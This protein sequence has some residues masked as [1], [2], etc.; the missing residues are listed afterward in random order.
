MSK[1]GQIVVGLPEGGEDGFVLVTSLVILVVLTIIGMA[2][3]TTTQIE[4]QISGNDRVIRRQFYKADG[5]IN[6]IIAKNHAP[7]PGT[8]VYAGL[9][10][11]NPPVIPGVGDVLEVDGL[12]Q[13][14]VDGDGLPDANIYLVVGN[15]N[16]VPPEIEVVSCATLNSATAQ[17]TAG[18]RFSNGGPLQDP[19]DE[20]TYNIQ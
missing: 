7:P 20:N 14:D 19:G 5:A 10:C 11:N 4:I 15:N 12:E 2:A 13:V 6:Y 17:I 3:L 1:R 8:P 9:D 16:H 18:I